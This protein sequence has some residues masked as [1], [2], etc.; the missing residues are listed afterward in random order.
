MRTAVVVAILTLIVVVMAVWFITG[1]G[2]DDQ[3]DRFNYT[4]IE[5]PTTIESGTLP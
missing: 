3:R 1:P 2:P 5:S 4:T